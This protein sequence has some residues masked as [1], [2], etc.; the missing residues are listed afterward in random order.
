MMERTWK[1]KQ[2]LYWLWLKYALQILIFKKPYDHEA[3]FLEP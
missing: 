1:K 2:G 3:L